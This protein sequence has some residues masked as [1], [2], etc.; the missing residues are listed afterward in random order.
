MSWMKTAEELEKTCFELIKE[1]Y[2]VERAFPRLRTELAVSFC[3]NKKEQLQAVYGYERKR[4][5]IRLVKD[6]C[7]IRQKTVTD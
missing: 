7:N 3:L 1:S 5:Q 4:I 2:D 6:Q